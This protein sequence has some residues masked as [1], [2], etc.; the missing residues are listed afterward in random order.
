MSTGNRSASSAV[1]CDENARA[2]R[3]PAGVTR[4]VSWCTRIDDVK[5]VEQ[6]SL[7][8]ASFFSL[9]DLLPAHVAPTRSKPPL[10]SET[11]KRTAN[12][13][14]RTC[15]HFSQSAKGAKGVQN[16]LIFEEQMESHPGGRVFFGLAKKKRSVL[17]ERFSASW[18]DRSVSARLLR[19][20]SSSV[21]VEGGEREK[22]QRGS[23]ERKTRE[24]GGESREQRAR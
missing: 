20:Q 13:L 21:S 15:E 24:G 7:T 3:A 16:G 6:H 4:A 10:P 22:L 17:R 2:D 5:E 23:A 14:K 19:S 18:H 11:Q 9:F 8:A 1:K 12:S